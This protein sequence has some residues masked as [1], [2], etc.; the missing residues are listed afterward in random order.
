VC[1]DRQSLIPGDARGP[2]TAAA[3]ERALGRIATLVAEGAAPE[4]VFAAVAVEVSRVLAVTA[5]TVARFDP[6][7]KVTVL[8]APST[9]G[10]EVGSRWPLE[11]RS[12]SA[13]ILDTGRSAR[14]DYHADDSGEHAAAATATG[15][16]S[17]VAVPVVIDGALWGLISAA[18]TDPEPL[19]GDTETRLEEFTQLVAVAISYAEAQAR[20]R[21]LHDER[22]AVRRVAKIVTEG[23]PVGDLLDA[24][25]REVVQLLEVPGGALL[26][27]D[28]RR[29]ATVLASVDFPALP[30]GTRF[31][32]DGP[33][34]AAQ[35]LDSGLPARIDDYTGL[36]SAIAASMRGAGFRSAFGVPITVDG[37]TWGL[38]GVGTNR[39]ERLPPD[40]DLR[41]RDLTELLASAI[42]NAEA[43]DRLRRLADRQ[44]ALRRVATLVAE[45][46]P[47][48]ELIASVVQEI[49][50]VLD[51]PVILI[52]RFEPERI[53]TVIASLNAAADAV[54]LRQFAVGTRWPLDGPSVAATVLDTGRPARIDDYSELG[55]TIAAGVRE[56]A[57]RSA[58]GVPIVVDRSV[59]GVIFVGT[60]ESEPLPADLE[61]RLEEFA[62]LVAVSISNAESRDRRARLA[63]QQAALRRVATLAAGGAALNEIFAAAAEEIARFVDVS[64]V[65]FV[66]YEAAG[67][68]VVVASF[69]EPSESEFAA[70][71]ADAG[72]EAE[73]GAP[74]VV[75]GRAWGMIGV[76]R[77]E[78]L[79]PV[80]VL[81]AGYQAR[82][83]LSTEPAEDVV[84]LLEPFTELVALAISRAQA[85]DDLRQLA[86]EQAALRRVATRVA[87]GAPP[88][89]IFDA[90][91]TE[92]AGTLGL[93]GIEMA[94]Y[95]AGGVATV[96][97][98]SGD[99][100]FPAGS[101]VSL[102]E[103]SVRSAVFQTGRPARI[104]DYTGLAGAVAQDTRSA[105]FR[106]AI[107]VP[108]VIEGAAWGAI[109]A[110]SKRPEPIPE[111]SE[112]RL[113]Q[114]TELVATAASN[115][116]ARADLIASRA[117]IV[118][119]GD[120]ARQRFERN[121]HD[122][123]QQ[124]LLALHLDL[125]QIR[126]SLPE[127]DQ[128]VVADVEQAERDLV[129]VLEEVREIS[130]GLHPPQLSRGGLFAAL[131]ALARRSPIPVEL[132]VDLDQ[133]PPAPIETAVYYVASE[134]LANAV[135]HSGAS[136]L[137]VVVGCTA[138]A[139]SATIA[140]DGVGGAVSGGGSGLVGL[141]DRVDAVGGR[142]V[143]DSPPGRGTKISIELPVGPSNS[144]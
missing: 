19:P 29:W 12:L 141:K 132:E 89:E 6:D 101:S 142:M 55:G 3:Y 72:V 108:I 129:A 84:A 118:A 41:L 40:A 2:S 61:P 87:E 27:Y 28:P 18:T 5:V 78:R 102:D 42:S 68:P 80:P 1:A 88:N 63:D 9:P 82:P 35:I 75:A 127:H 51:A 111:R 21:Q 124:H 123:T 36:D 86:E 96:I 37:A 47:A 22:A 11:G 140:D 13:T 60:M 139:L 120:A 85:Y 50:R 66:R 48:A 32:L 39:A 121:L 136:K 77:Q 33:S 144:R 53:T 125:Q 64:R 115:A 20:L 74:I 38:I 57:M 128:Q 4:A 137:S 26:R 79:E 113:S 65:R 34:L 14:A 98:A 116:T 10:V 93:Q 76:G 8:A 92:I 54:N 109:I 105:G 112:L 90:V 46:V 23:R 44:A 104:D 110:F 95:D 126:A 43:R 59:W 143:L 71:T 130:R 49:E 58:L 16:R 31:P 103:P 131:R 119:A 62:E 52:G 106:S 81:A 70:A 97:S 133:R 135:K 15:M 107:G 100:P 138:T 24:V 134:A 25:V 45:G 91:V 122:G 56:T 117:R 73:V 30:L 7:R 17:A 67:E 114:F 94:R 69:T 99:H 83:V